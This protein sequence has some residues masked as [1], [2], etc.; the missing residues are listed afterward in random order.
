[1]SEQFLI[2]HLL[3]LIGYAALTI[4]YLDMAYD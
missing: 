3:I 1:M 2:S 4:G